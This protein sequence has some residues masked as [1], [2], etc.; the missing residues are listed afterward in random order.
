MSADRTSLQST[1]RGIQRPRSAFFDAGAHARLWSV[2]AVALALDLWSKSWAFTSLGPTEV[3]QA[4]PSILTFRRSVNAGALFGMGKGLVPLFIFASLIALGFVIYLFA[5]STADRKS[6][7]LGLSCVLAGS[8]GNLYDR[9]FIIADSVFFP[10]QNQRIIGKIIENDVDTNYIKIGLAP[11][12]AN[13]RSIPRR[14]AQIGR[15]GV[16]RDFLKIEPKIGNQDVW[17]WVFNVADSLLVVGVSIL[18]LNFWFER[19][20]TPR[21][22]Q[23]SAATSPSM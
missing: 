12:G 22:R 8:L 2:A 17:P 4:I 3:R 6:L 7:H 14:D 15:V 9:T 20:T 13:P 10:S 11:D 18:M 1:L 21:R 19:K 23:D 5:T 16:V